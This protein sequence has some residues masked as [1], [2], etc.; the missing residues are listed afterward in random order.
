MT[1]HLCPLEPATTWHGSL[2]A[3][4]AKLK[5]A[6]R[7]DDDELDILDMMLEN[8]MEDARN[9]DSLFQEME[10]VK[11]GMLDSTVKGGV[12]DSHLPDDMDPNQR[13]KI[14][15]EVITRCFASFATSPMIWAAL[16]AGSLVGSNKAVV[17]EW[18]ALH[19]IKLRLAQKLSLIQHEG[20][21]V[22]GLLTKQGQ[23]KRARI[24]KLCTCNIYDDTAPTPDWYVQYTTRNFLHFKV[25]YGTGRFGDLIILKG[26][27]AR[28]KAAQISKDQG[29]DQVGVGGEFP[30]HSLSTEQYDKNLF[31]AYCKYSYDVSADAWC[32]ML[33]ENLF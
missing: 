22:A 27:I 28:N 17:A 3:L 29:L 7:D 19:E 16:G 5:E 26:E 11:G 9:W 25:K 20:N 6:H 14:K 31:E 15:W 30:Y 13:L 24:V 10:A 21:R 12:L 1:V 8:V 18:L 4:K 32:Y 23:I 2:Q 33:M